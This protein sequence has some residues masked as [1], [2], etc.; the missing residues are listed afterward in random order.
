MKKIVIGS[1]ALVL[2]VVFSGCA[3]KVPTYSPKT[4]NIMQLKGMSS[5]AKTSVGK[6][7]D[8]GNE[9]TKVMCR[10]ATPIGT[11]SGETFT[12]YIQDA[13]TQELML[14]DKFDPKSSNILTANLNDIYGST[15]LGNAYWEFKVTVKSS[16]GT[17]FDTNSRYD[18]DSSYF[19]GSA[20][21]EMQRSFVPA[22]Q[23]LNNEIINNPK[24]K[25][26]LAQ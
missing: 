11:P 6:F 3:N 10:L 15:T 9:E 16:N 21:S 20:C 19:A 14:A 23:K 24:F 17:S 8:S 13:L 25:D 1:L 5:D 22:V 18:Y 2:T 7:T 12:S 26:L 4:A